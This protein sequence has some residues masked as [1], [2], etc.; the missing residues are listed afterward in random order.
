MFQ[1]TGAWLVGCGIYD[2]V[3]EGRRLAHFSFFYTVCYN[4]VSCVVSQVGPDG[5]GAV[6]CSKSYERYVSAFQKI[7]AVVSDGK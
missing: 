3:K 6:D 5:P 7:K 1:T 4:T 2:Y